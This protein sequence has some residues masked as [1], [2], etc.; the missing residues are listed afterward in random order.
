MIKRWSI[1]C[2]TCGDTDV[3]HEDDT[4]DTVYLE[5]LKPLIGA[6]Y[7]TTNMAPS[8]MEQNHNRAVREL[9]TLLFDKQ[10]S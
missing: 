9:R 3:A 4:G 10:S 8:E 6:L 2:V 1:Q 7:M 5:D